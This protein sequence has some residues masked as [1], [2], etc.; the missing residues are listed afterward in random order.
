MSASPELLITG[1]GT[2]GHVSPGLGVAAVWQARHGAG[3]AAW[4]GRHEGVEQEM[5]ERAGLAFH[6]LDSAAFKRQW[7]LNNLAIPGVLLKGLRQGTELIRA[8][9]PS[10]VLM[11]GG[12]VGLPLSL[13][14]LRERVPLVLLE[15]NA[16]PG[17][18]NRLLKPLAA[19]LCLA[20]PPAAPDPKC[21]VT[22]TPCRPLAAHAKAAARA[23]LG[24][25]PDKR[26]LLVLPGSQAARAI[27]AALRDSLEPLAD[28]AGQWQWI[29]MGGTAEMMANEAAAARSGL[30]IQ[31]RGFIQD[32]ALAYAACDLVLCRSGAS[33]LAE[34]GLLGLPSLQV[35][36]P[37]ATGDHQRANA[38]AFAEAGAARM[39]DPD[40][41]TPAS[42]QAALR[43][44]LDDPAQLAG[45][46][47]AA[48]GLGK[49]DAA[50][51]VADQLELAAGLKAPATGDAHAQ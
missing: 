19:K 26:T 11:T 29:W 46:A 45:M 8:R 5:A 21:E 27:N 23:S 9:R 2:G 37:H 15:P 38:G 31:V 22:G 42:L 33:T 40:S 4:V 34:L 12:Y 17:L 16:V 50:E 28:R 13:A 35:P 10:A 25:D 20:Y 43:A 1:G 18:A 3:S 14:A 32:V 47:A 24:L 44:L 49:P 30:T 39:L 7:T 6:G 51:K 48:K 36:Y 41:L